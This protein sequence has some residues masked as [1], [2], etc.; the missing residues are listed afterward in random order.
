M[1]DR[2]MTAPLQKR[3]TVNIALSEKTPLLLVASMAAVGLVAAGYLWSFLPFD[4]K[5][6]PSMSLGELFW[7][8]R[9]A[10]L[11]AAGLGGMCFSIAIVRRSEGLRRFVAFLCGVICLYA[12]AVGIH[13][14]WSTSIRYG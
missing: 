12:F 5:R 9:G 10:L 6:E 7:A 8:I 14:F 1:V 13:Y 3:M 4:Y 11:I 2:K